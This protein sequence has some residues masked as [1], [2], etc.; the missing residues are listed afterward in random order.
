MLYALSDFLVHLSQEKD[1]R[2]VSEHYARFKVQNDFETAKKENTKLLKRGFNAKFLQKLNTGSSRN[3]SV[4]VEDDDFY[5]DANGD[6]SRDAHTTP[7]HLNKKPISHIVK[8]LNFT[9]Q[10]Q[11]H[12]MRTVL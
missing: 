6:T 11:R 7:R 8:P 4:V 2:P 5:F 9:E 10:A 12:T 1:I 3:F